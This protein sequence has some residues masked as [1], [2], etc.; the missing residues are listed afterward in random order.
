[1]QKS[2]SLNDFMEELSPWLDRDHVKNAHIDGD[3]RL[4]L[5]FL[6]GMRHVYSIT[7]CNKSQVE[8]ILDDLRGKGIAVVE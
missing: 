4:V 6:D 7:D 1:M 5:F 8:N 2:C 3:G